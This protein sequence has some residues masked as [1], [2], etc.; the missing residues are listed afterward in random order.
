[1]RLKSWRITIYRPYASPEKFS[2]IEEYDEALIAELRE[3][4]H[5]FGV[6]AGFL[7]IVGEK[8]INRFQKGINKCH[9]S[10]I[11][12]FLRKRLLWNKNHMKK[13]WNTGRKVRGATVHFVGTGT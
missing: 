4:K 2:T 10:L 11:P 1:M 6:M 7:S 3:K 9:P 13:R 12:S 5:G 8:F